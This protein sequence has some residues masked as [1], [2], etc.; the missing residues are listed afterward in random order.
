[1][2]DLIGGGIIPITYNPTTIT[3]WVTVNEKTYAK[4]ILEKIKN[5]ID[6]LNSRK[7]Y[8]TYAVERPWDEMKNKVFEIFDKYMEGLT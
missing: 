7:C 5:E 3:T 2:S 1:M 4:D 6:N 8:E